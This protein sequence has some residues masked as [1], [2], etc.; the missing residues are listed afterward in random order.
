MDAHPFRT[1]WQTRNLD[2]WAAALAPDVVLHSPLIQAP[3]VGREV[4]VELYG[5]LFE[6]LGNVDIT[7]ESSDGDS[8]AFFWRAQLGARSIEGTDLLRYDE[9]G[10][11]AEVTVLLRPL[12]AIATFAAAV[13]P[14]LAAKQNPVKGVLARVLTMP[15]RS[16]FLAIDAIS[17]RVGQRG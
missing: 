9:H 4:A 10:Q 12:V 17:T 11:I 6:V 16:L 2:D 8:H 7:H 5:T 13:G 3:F 1:A 14:P 15:L